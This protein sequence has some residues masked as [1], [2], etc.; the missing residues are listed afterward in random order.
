MLVQPKPVLEGNILIHFAWGLFMEM[1]AFNDTKQCT[2]AKLHLTY[3][4]EIYT[5]RF[6]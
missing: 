5:C 6:E 2:G 3:I 4:T 1:K